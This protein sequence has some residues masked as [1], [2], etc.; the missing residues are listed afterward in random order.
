MKTKVK[1]QK[2]V[3]YDLEKLLCLKKQQIDKYKYELSSKSNYNH[4]YQMIKSF[5]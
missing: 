5:L 3:I 4:Y 1:L 2:K